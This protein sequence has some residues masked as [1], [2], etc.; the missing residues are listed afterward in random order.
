MRR[1]K[2]GRDTQADNAR[3][4]ELH[5]GVRDTDTTRAVQMPSLACGSL[6]SISIPLGIWG[7]R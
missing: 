7:R 2:V 1:R 5:R 6:D 4:L 3:E